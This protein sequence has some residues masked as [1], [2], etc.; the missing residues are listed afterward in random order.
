MTKQD[1]FLAFV[2]GIFTALFALPIVINLGIGIP[3]F[4]LTLF[5]IFP[6]VWMFG[7]WFGEFL[8][9]W[10]KFFFQFG[11]FAVVGFF[12]AAVDFGVLNVLIFLTGITAGAYYSLFKASS[13]IVANVNSYFW[14]KWWTFKKKDVLEEGM[15]E[16]GAAKQ[17]T[18]FFIVSVI[19]LGLNVGAASLVVN[20]VGPQFGIGAAGWANIGAVAGSAAGLIWNFVGYKFIVFK[21]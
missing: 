9:R 1:Y 16:P 18:Q 3:Y 14:N 11:K 20:I 8:S 4:K 17:Y 7:I 5:I 2:A 13:F 12:N 15:G 21:A 6:I 19:G 10:F